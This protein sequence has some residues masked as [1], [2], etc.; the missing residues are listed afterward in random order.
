[1]LLSLVGKNPNI[2][3]IREETSRST[4]VS[5]L[6]TTLNT[7]IAYLRAMTYLRHMFFVNTDGHIRVNVNQIHLIELQIRHLMN[8]A[9]VS[10][11]AYEYAFHHFQLL[12][13]SARTWEA[14][15]LFKILC[16][17]SLPLR[18][19]FSPDNANLS[20]CPKTAISKENYLRSMYN[21]LKA[22]IGG[23][24]LLLKLETAAQ[25]TRLI[26]GVHSQF[27]RR[28]CPT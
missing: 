3:L 28:K 11:E 7:T 12:T 20:K 22:A 25:T 14:A 5:I 23:Q 24:H 6:K 17:R 1:M 10:P 26:S 27:F 21:E 4:I 19:R 8:N 15:Q 16:P 13:G 2:D 18:F 9:K